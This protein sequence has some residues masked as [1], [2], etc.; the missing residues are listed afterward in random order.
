MDKLDSD[1]GPVSAED[2]RD[3]WDVVMGVAQGIG[4]MNTDH[5]V[6]GDPEEPLYEQL[7]R[8]DRLVRITDD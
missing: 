5:I 7:L 6:C 8:F 1:C 2:A 4:A 3:A